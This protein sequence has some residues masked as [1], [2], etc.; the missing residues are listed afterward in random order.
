[1]ARLYAALYEHVHVFGQRRFITE[2]VSNFGLIGFNDRVSSIAVFKGR[3]FQKGD[4]IR[5]FEHAHYQ[6]GFLD[7]GPGYYYDIHVHPFSFG[8][9]M[10]SAQFVPVSNEPALF[11]P[12]IVRVY[13]HV[14]FEGEF[15]DIVMDERNLGN[16]GF[17]DRISSFEVLHGDDV[18]ASHVCDFFQHANF[19]GGMLQPGSF[20]PGISVPSLT[21]APFSFN[22]T[23]SS[24]RI[25]KPT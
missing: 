16:Q 18:E 3:D 1:M 7:L 17:N 25:H 5:F 21:A 23:I 15:R 20:A 8:D 11:V 6:G 10:S 22:D 9:K 24:V 13:Q 19:L 12:L 4:K 2:S 14:N